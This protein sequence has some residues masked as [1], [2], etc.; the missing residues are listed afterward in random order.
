MGGAPGGP[1]LNIFPLVM[2]T[3]VQSMGNLFWKSG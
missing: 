2:S 1:E 3:W